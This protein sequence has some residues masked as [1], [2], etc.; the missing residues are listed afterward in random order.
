MEV[1][2]GSLPGCLGVVYHRCA[3][4]TQRAL[5]R[6][7]SPTI[8]PCNAYSKRERTP[9]HINHRSR[10]TIRLRRYIGNRLEG[11]IQLH[12]VGGQ[13]AVVAR[14]AIANAGGL[15]RAITARISHGSLGT[16]CERIRKN[17]S[18]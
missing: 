16:M 14:L 18:P 1:I 8:L 4:V 10:D 11:I 5:L 9:P 17:G 15:K 7:V 12:G 13:A 2:A 6:L 3:N